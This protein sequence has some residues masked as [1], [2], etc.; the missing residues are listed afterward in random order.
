MAT[1]S[2][3]VTAAVTGPGFVTPTIVPGLTRDLRVEVHANPG[4]HATRTLT[5]RTSSE[6][7]PAR[8]DT[9]KAIVSRS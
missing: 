6:A 3:N 7:A 8:A 1:G 5:I 9:V 4:G 2:Q